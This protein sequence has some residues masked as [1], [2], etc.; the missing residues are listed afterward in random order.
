[1]SGVFTT[2]LCVSCTVGPPSAPEIPPD[3]DDRLPSCG[4][5]AVGQSLRNVFQSQNGAY[6]L[7]GV[8]PP[9]R[10]EVQQVR[11]D[12]AT[13]AARTDEP[14]RARHPRIGGRGRGRTRPRG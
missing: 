10:E 1:M 14:G 7:V 12:P 3:I 11:E 9:G 13:V 5:D 6:Q 8:E 4:T 2:L